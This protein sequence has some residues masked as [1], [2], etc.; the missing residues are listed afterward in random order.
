M[1]KAYIFFSVHEQLFHRMAERLRERGVDSFS[2]F[3]WGKAQAAD[4][5]NLGI[6]YDPLV[7][8]TRDLLPTYDDA[9]PDL[10]WLAKRERELGISIQRMLS[11]ERH[12]LAGRTFE[13]IM[14]VAEVALREIA[15]ALDR[16]RPDFLFSEDISCFHSYVHFVLA[17]ERGIPFW[18]I[19]GARLPYRIAVYSSGMQRWERLEAILGELRR[20]G[21]DPAER[22][23]AEDYIADFRAR[24]QRPS[25]MASRAAAPGLRRPD[26]AILRLAARRYWNDRNDPTATPPLRAVQQRLRRMARIR[27][28]DL[29]DVFEEPV[30]GENYVLYPIHFQPEAS[31]LVQAPMYVDQVALLEDMARSLPIGYRLY[32]K[33][34]L[35][36]RGR[37]PLAFY[38]ALRRIPSVR[39][40]GPDVDTWSLT[41]NAGAIAVITGTMGWEGL[42]FGKPVITFGDVF[43]N[44][45]PHVYRASQVPKDGWYELFAAALTSHVPDHEALL[46]YVAAMQLS[47]YPGFIGNPVSFPDVL[48]DENVQLLVDGLA[49]AAGLAPATSR[50]QS[51]AP[52]H[53]HR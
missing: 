25:G 37:R 39:L 11:A 15:A 8:F 20:R 31:T 35:S 44:A 9:P 21:L 3:A 38:Q 49:D 7:V 43:Y 36:N 40:L 1:T 23:A 41:R 51:A 14:R 32:V 6:T 52:P 29:F 30:E 46:V 50:V 24:P 10:A 5:E 48:L 47:S 12:L 34:H 53:L 42:L 16:I 27:G 13:Q 28:A 2:G 17:R 22:Q 18:C 45:V 26:L 19:G 4:L 33:E